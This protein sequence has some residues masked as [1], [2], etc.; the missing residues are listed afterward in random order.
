MTFIRITKEKGRI[1]KEKGRITKE[2]GDYTQN[3]MFFNL[4]PTLTI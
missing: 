4:V 1:T 2:K 3:Q